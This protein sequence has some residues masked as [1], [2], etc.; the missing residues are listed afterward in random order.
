MESRDKRVLE[1]IIMFC[2]RI[3]GNLERYHSSREEFERDTL[4]QDACCM[5]VVQI[6]ELAAQLSETV[7]GENPQVPWRIIKDT[8]NFYVHSYGSVD[9]DSVWT[10]LTE[11]IPV[12]R[13]SCALILAS[14]R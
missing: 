4:F 8:R 5:C 10:T 6:G 2:D 14:E 1:R 12:L 7:R 11:D 13:E 3:A 9:T